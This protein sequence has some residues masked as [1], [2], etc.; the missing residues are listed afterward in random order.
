MNDLVKMENNQVVTSSKQVAEVFGKEHKNVL[1]DIDNI[2]KVDGLKIEPM[3]FE[4]TEPD[5]YGRM[6]KVYYMNRDGFSLLAMGF[7]GKKALD[8][9]LKYIEAFNKMEKTIQGGM[10][11]PNFQDPAAMAE[12]WAKQYRLTQAAQ[13]A[14]EEAKPKIEFCNDLTKGEKD[15]SFR[16]YSTMTGIDASILTQF[17]IDNKWIYRDQSGTRLP[18]SGKKDWFKMKWIRPNGKCMPNIYITPK[19]QIELWQELKNNNM[20]PKELR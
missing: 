16:K 10:E 17:C 3:F 4:G 19:G 14:L 15:V 1:R 18:Y 12:A 9:K 7:T 20:N 8:W 11:L 13:K 6:K 5:T 2:L